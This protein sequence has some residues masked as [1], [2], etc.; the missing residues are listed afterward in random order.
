MYCAMSE[1]VIYNIINKMVSLQ[2]IH[3]NAPCAAEDEDIEMF[4]DDLIEV[5]H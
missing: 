4:F 5:K 2:S 1:R 3:G